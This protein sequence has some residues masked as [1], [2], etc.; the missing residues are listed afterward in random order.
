MTRSH[1]KAFS[2]VVLAAFAVALGGC[3]RDSYDRQCY[4]LGAARERAPVEARIDGALEVRR[5]SVDAAF[6][7]KCFVYRVAE[8]EYEP[9]YYHQFLVPPGILLTD[10]TRQWLSD[11]GLFERVLPADTRLEPTY[12]LEGSVAALYGDF[13]DESASQAVLEIRYFL[14]NSGGDAE[15]VVFTETYRA[16][17][18]IPEK[19]AAAFVGALDNCLAEILTRLEADLTNHQI[20][21]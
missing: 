20:A 4:V 12:T 10:K 19:T 18:P 5:L 21:K 14:L 6:S 16:A 3:A 9:D 7:G 2:W 11:C 15:T 13:T 1:V 8:H 17:T